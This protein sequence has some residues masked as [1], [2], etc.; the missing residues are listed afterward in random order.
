MGISS[1]IQKNNAWDEYKYLVNGLAFLDTAH[2][3]D[4]DVT[5]LSMVNALF[6]RGLSWSFERFDQ[7]L[8]WARLPTLF[9]SA[10]ALLTTFWW[11]RRHEG[12][13]PAIGALI[14]YLFSPN[15]MAHARLVSPDSILASLSLLLVCVI[16]IYTMRPSW[17]NVGIVGLVLGMTLLAKF[18]GIIWI[19]LSVLLVAMLNAR[20]S[21]RLVLSMF[22]A[23]IV[24]WIG[25]GMNFLPHYPFAPDLTTY[26]EGLQDVRHE[27]SQG[28]P[29]FIAGERGQGW[30]YY[31]ILLILIKTTIPLLVLSGVG[32][33]LGIRYAKTRNLVALL[34]IPAFA[35]VCCASLTNM[36]LGI[37]HILL[38][39]PLLV[40]LGGIGIFH[41]LKANLWGKWLVAILLL[42]H[43]GASV[44]I[45]PHYLAYFNE[46]VG[47]PNNGWRW[48]VDSNLD[49]GQDLKGLARYVNEHNIPSIYLAYFGQGFPQCYPAPFKYLPSA[50]S[51][52]KSSIPLK[53]VDPERLHGWV[54]ISA[55]QLQ[56][57]W[58][59]V[60]G[61]PP[62][63][64]AQFKSVAP[65]TKIGY[66]IFIYHLP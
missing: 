13:L 6:V 5:P 42:W 7:D 66:S 61:L 38:V 34:S 41:L 39:Y 17:Y 23:A 56:G 48:A 53:F 45:Y 27:L 15:I 50:A 44:F 11:T 14:L 22:V 30:W 16:W 2:P 32:I 4:L 63:L 1:A 60:F 59:E 29:S 31:Y 21:V 9:M 65:V 36:S 3:I 40:M 25:Y 10:I 20:A 12:R 37:R 8:F 49:W 54:A 43:I 35:S 19:P 26:W 52:V 47:G 55:T 18:S 58:N 51:T 64:Y 46:T 62:D 33:F 24:L 57:V 28:F